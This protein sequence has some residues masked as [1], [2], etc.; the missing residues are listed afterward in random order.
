MRNYIMKLSEQFRKNKD[1]IEKEKL[2]LEMRRKY[3]PQGRTTR[4][5]GEE[6]VFAAPY[7]VSWFLEY[8]KDNIM[9]FYKIGE[10]DNETK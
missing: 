7:S 10:S 4:G 8:N 1:D 9:K 3:C 5:L 2:I 6:T